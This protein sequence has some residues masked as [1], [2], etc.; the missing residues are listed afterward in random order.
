MILEFNT[1]QWVWSSIGA[2]Y[3]S[4]CNISREA[5]MKLEDVDFATRV[6]C[7]KYERCHLGDSHLDTE[8]I[9]RAR[10]MYDSH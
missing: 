6:W 1:D 10:A 2:E 4:Q 9:P 3:G 7:A 8:R 5:F